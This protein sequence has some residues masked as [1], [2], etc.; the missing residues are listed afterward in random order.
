MVLTADRGVSLVVLDKEDYTAKSEELL[1]QSN[2][3]ILKTDPT[4]KCQNKL[5]ALLKSIKADGGID[6]NTYRRL[7]PTGAV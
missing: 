2:Y 5:I 6:D 1:H 4:S 3:K 7:Y